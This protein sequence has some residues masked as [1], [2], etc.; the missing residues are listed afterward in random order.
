MEAIREKRKDKAMF[1]ISSAETGTVLLNRRRIS[2]ALRWWLRE[3]GISYKS[4]FY[5]G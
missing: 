4:S 3:N 5:I 2:K 1:L